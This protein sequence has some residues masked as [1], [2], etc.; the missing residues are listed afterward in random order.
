M[1]GDRFTPMPPAMLA[2]E[3][4]E[5]YLYDVMRLVPLREPGVTLEPIAPDSL[6]DAGFRARGPGRADVELYVSARDGRLA[7]LRTR[8][9]DPA[10]A[11]TTMLQDLWLDGAVE[12]DGVRWPR[13]IRITM[14]GAPYFELT[15]RSLSTS[16]R[17]TEVMLKGPK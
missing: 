2:N 11:G 5:F 17:L 12:A 15:V 13:T 16:R 10:A 14:N 4:D 6:G 1:S 3:R 9:P 7:H 8:V